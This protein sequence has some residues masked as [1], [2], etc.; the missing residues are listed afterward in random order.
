MIEI[1]SRQ[2]GAQP[3]AEQVANRVRMTEPF[4]LDDFNGPLRHSLFQ[5]FNR[6]RHWTNILCSAAQWSAK[7]TEPIYIWCVWTASMV[8]LLRRSANQFKMTT[9]MSAASAAWLITMTW[10][11]DRG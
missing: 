1:I 10:N 8:S 6:N 5:Y 7:V 9:S 11:T 2:A 4:A 3:L